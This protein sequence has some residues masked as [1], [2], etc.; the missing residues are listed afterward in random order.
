MKRNSS[1]VPYI[2]QQISELSA[3]QYFGH[4]TS[5]TGLLVEVLAPLC[6]QTIGRQAIIL[7]KPE[8]R[9]EVI[10]FNN[11]HALM[12]VFG[13]YEGLGVG[14]RVVFKEEMQCIFPTIHWIGRVV[15]AMGAPIDNKGPLEKGE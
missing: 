8:R 14:Q 2:T 12:M 11:G 7:A 4:V 6:I 10:G 9:A 15:D 5:I 1:A 3:V 13:S